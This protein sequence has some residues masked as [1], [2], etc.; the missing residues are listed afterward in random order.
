MPLFLK[1]RPRSARLAAALLGLWLGLGA[2]LRAQEANLLPMPA[3]AA[4]GTGE[5]R[6]DGG[7]QIVLEGFDEPRLRRASDRFAE[8]LRERTG[9]ARWPPAGPSTP[10][11]VVRAAGPSEPVQKLGEDESY[12]M[13]VTSSAVQLTAPNPL[14]ILHGLQTFLQLVHASPEGF[15]A[16]AAAI[17]DS[18]RFPW[19][20][21]MIDTGRHFMPLE[22]IR[23]NLDLMEAAK[24]NVLHWHL[25][26]DQGFRVESRVFPLLQ[27]KGSDGLFYTQAEVRDTIAYAR[28][29]G[30]RVVPEFDMPGH[31]A[32]W[33]VG[34]PELA[35][36]QGPYSIVRTWGIFD[37][38]MDPT[39]DSTYAFLDRFLGEMTALFPDAYFHI[40][41]DECNGK[42]WD[43]SPR[44]AEWKRGH[45]LAD[46]AALQAYFT[47][48][49]QK[50]VTA[51]GKVTVG[52]DEVLQPGTP[53]DVVIQ[54]WRGQDS[55]AQA[56]RGGNRG[57]LSWGYYLDLNEPASQH[58]AV[59]PLGDSAAAL[60]PE[61]QARILGGEA[62]EWTEYLTP[63][64]LTGRIW[65]RAAAV[66]ERLW[67]PQ[68]VTDTA[69]MYR[70]LGL[71]EQN[72]TWYGSDP[73]FTARSTFRRL[74]GPGS[75]AQ[76]E[77]LADVVEPPKEYTREE[78]RS[79][80]V[81]TPLD[82]MVDAVPAESAQARRF[83]ALAGRIGGGG[84]SPGE[85]TEMREWLTTLAANDRALAPELSASALT[86]ELAPVSRDLSRA[87]VMGLT[88]LAALGKQGTMDAAAQQADLAALKQMEAPQ[89]VL[90]DGAV[91][92][93]EILVRAVRP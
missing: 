22:V 15:V 25:S 7:V 87:A 52:W 81:Y 47:A 72:L 63:E 43:R 83:T 53:K 36:G 74:A 16:D 56:A 27:G 28:D 90:L 82:R 70:R 37:P 34:Y 44:I 69:S 31:A 21:L 19:R 75:S 8:Q 13:A 9:V 45:G 4:P 89:A 11:F 51:H 18:P 86:A 67:S 1:H 66:A 54:S 60:S 5:L 59:D 39:R 40:G 80:S 57:L 46:D 92:A 38:A 3:K 79:Y 61:E 14:G 84:A 6:L 42:E 73:D 35:S 85:I 24:L 10:R 77:V 41:G 76:L 71:F 91:P 12:H 93:V 65:P 23:Q 64:I 26:D 32:S 17:D 49:V 29:R 30:I 33:F 48:R 58:Y 88:A 62:A 50:L 20:G 55:L 78:L 2:A 68:S